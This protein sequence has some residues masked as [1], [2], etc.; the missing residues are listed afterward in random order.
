MAAGASAGT[1]LNPNNPLC[2]FSTLSE[3]MLRNTFCF[4]VTNIPVYVNGQ[5]VYTPAVNRVLQLAANIYDAS[6]TNFYPSVFR[7][8]FQIDQFTNLFIVGYTEV[9]NVLSI[10]PG[11]DIQFSLPYDV[12]QLGGLLNSGAVL[13]NKPFDTNIYGVPWIIGAKKNLPTFNQFSMLNTVTVDR[14]LQVTRS[15]IVSP[16]YTNHLY[17]LS[18][19][20]V[21]DASF[22]NS[23]SNNYVSP[24]NGVS[25][26][27]S[28]FLQITL[29]SSTAPGVYTSRV[30]N[31]SFLFN[32]NS[33]PGSRWSKLIGET[34][35]NDAFIATAWTNT[36]LS[37]VIY[38]TGAKVFAQ[39]SDPDPW[40]TNNT[41]CDPLPDFEL[42]TTNWLRAI[43][44]DNGHVIDYVQ[45]RGP[46]DGT[47][48]TAALADP[49][50]PGQS[51]QLY[52]WSTNGY[53]N[54]TL[55]SWGYVSQM[56]ISKGFAAAPASAIWSP[57]GYPANLTTVAAGEEYFNAFFT[58]THAFT[59]NGNVYYSTDAVLQAGY[60]ATRTIFVPYL[61]QVNDPMVHFLASDLDA[62]AGAVWNG[63]NALPNGVWQQNNGVNVSYQTPNPP[64]GADI[65]RGRYQP[66]GI[67][68]PLAL[69][70]A[71]YNFSNPFNLIYKDPGVWDPDDWNFPTNLL[72]DLTG[73]GQ[74]HRGTP[75]QTVY[76][77][78]TNVIVSGNIIGTNTWAAWAGDLNLSDAAISA[79]VNDWQLASLMIA[80]LNTNNITQ[81]ISANDPNTAD[82]LNVLN[83]LTAYSNTTTLPPFLLRNGIPIPATTFDTYV[84]DGDSTQAEMIAKGIAQTRAAQPNQDFYSVG[85]ILSAPELTVSSPWLNTSSASQL[86]YGITDAAYEAIPAQ[87]LLLLRPDSIGALSLTNGGVNLQFSG[88]D[89]LSYELQQSTDL[90]HWFALSTNNPARGVFNVIIPSVPGSSQQFY[91]TVLLP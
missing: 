70:S 32:T 45:L 83:G 27:L 23:Y 47:N 10:N 30:F 82:W 84:M 62:G 86:A 80:L 31:N 57:V 64:Y 66:W 40:E 6:T 9:T 54:C 69:Q 67:A 81:L 87:L 20:N 8:V 71:A 65:T 29:N 49:P 61:Y 35:A 91:R 26:F 11:E 24:V 5:F 2:F 38:K 52:L 75:W 72:A 36:F 88:S 25:V 63:N 51:G 22:W 76:L 55:P 39:L 73:L 4:G 18:I 34:P 19:S 74:V 50:S 1:V 44:V 89:A 3:K 33:W 41:S 79:P 59:Y 48:F 56:N 42:T 43:I 60:T 46:I 16:I 58:P 28:D 14:E 13:A 53:G 12:S 68:A 77:K 21:L 85:D 90:V 37:S 7:P 78:T 15:T 17:L